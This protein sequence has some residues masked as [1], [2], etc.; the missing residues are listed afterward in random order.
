MRTILGLVAMASA[1]PAAAQMDPV[2][3]AQGQLLSATMRGHAARLRRGVP[4]KSAAQRKH[5]ADC[6]QLWQLRDRMT[7]AQRVRLYD[8]CPR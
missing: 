2:V 1:V 6:A 5:E 8:L 3:T 4:P 7:R